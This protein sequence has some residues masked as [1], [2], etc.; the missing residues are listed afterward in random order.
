MI[1]SE[2]PSALSWSTMTVRMINTQPTPNLHRICCFFW[3]SLSLWGLMKLIQKYSKIWLVPL[4]GHSKWFL[5]VL[6]NLERSQ[7]TGSWQK[8]PVFE[9]GKRVDS[10][11]YKPVTFTSVWSKIMP[12]KGSSLE[13]G[14]AL[15]QALQ[16][17]GHSTK[18][19]RVQEVFG[20]CFQAHSVILGAVL[21][22]ARSWTPSWGVLGKSVTSKGQRKW[23]SFTVQPLWGQFRSIVFK[24]VLHSSRK[25]RSYW[26]GSNG[27]KKGDEGL[28]ISPQARRDC[29]SWA[30]LVWRALRGD[31]INGYKYLKGWCQQD[32]AQQQ[33]KY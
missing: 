8:V 15:E 28:R 16:S 5:S 25:T 32:G 7:S 23:F 22:R 26:R 30:W 29:E 20:Q 2:G 12:K 27:G 13:G 14:Q 17:S 1:S 31:P 33:E 3:L 4:Q 9:K 24:S 18:P 6:G 11:N 19:T 10:G 21:S